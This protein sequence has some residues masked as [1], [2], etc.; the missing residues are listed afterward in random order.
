VPLPDKIVAGTWRI[1]STDALVGT[2]LAKD[3]GASVGDKIHLQAPTGADVT[4][5][6]TGI[7]DL[8]SRGVNERNVYV[9]LRTSQDLLNLIGGVS[10]IDVTVDDIW[11]AEDVAQRIS[12]F[13]G[14]QADSWI[15]TNQ[16]FFIALRAQTIS[17]VVLRISVGISVALGI[18]SVLVVSVV[19][20]SREIGILRAMG[21][22]RRQIMNV[23]LIQGAVVGLAGSFIGSGLAAMA[24]HAWV[25]TLKNPDGTPLFLLEFDPHLLAWAA[26]IAT[27][28]GLLAA[29]TPARRAAR[30]DPVVAIRA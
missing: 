12:A 29:V 28:T 9:L 17:N 22:S 21:A 8:G 18:A 2:E 25:A 23:F 15:H 24:L 14:L 11:A 30:L 1:M 5:T 6:I 7:F 19:Q 16:Q 20:K 13:V 4:L 27:L 3:L 26:A 10:N